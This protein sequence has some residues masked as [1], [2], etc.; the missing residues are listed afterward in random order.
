MKTEKA[1]IIHQGALGD[2]I[3]T[4]PAINALRGQCRQVLGIGSPRLKFLEQAGVL[5]QALSADALGFHRL[6]LDDF[7]PKDRLLSV[8]EGAGLAVS[9]MGRNSEPFRKNL[10]RLARRV[11]IFS[12]A[13]PPTKDQGHA[14]KVLAQPVLDL[15]IE[16][17]DL[18]PRLRLPGPARPE[19]IT[20]P[21]D[22]EFIALHPGSGGAKKALPLQKLL[23]ILGSLARLF[24]S[25]GLVV[26]GAEL[27]KLLLMELVKKLPEQLRPRVRLIDGANLFALAH[28]LIRSRLFIG[29]DS[30]PT[31]LAASL[32]V[33]TIALFGPTDPAVWA[34]PQP[35]VRVVAGGCDC[36][37]CAEA[38]RRN[39]SSSKCLEAIDDGQ[40]AKAAAELIADQG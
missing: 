14:C 18:H 36:A 5:D 32:G 15:G 22:Q 24:P 1:I 11:S 2:L 3:C 26:L 39:C 4:L 37:P 27:E 25:K 21:L 12:A 9:W 23:G 30:G 33:R 16:V 19:E 29:T 13:F 8:F 6:F 28:I 10:H 34:P 31:H 17:R 7:S 38:A 40:I 35:W 20:P